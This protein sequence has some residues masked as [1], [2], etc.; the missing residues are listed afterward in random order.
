MRGWVITPLEDG[1][2]LARAGRERLDFAVATELAGAAPKRLAHQVRQ[3]LWRALQGLRGFSPVVEIAGD[4]VRAG[5]QVDGRVP[6]NAV[7]I[8]QGVLD[9]PANRARWM[10]CAK[11][12]MT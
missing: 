4:V 12:R 5:G 3:D 10:R 11:R 7:A 9:D 8:A 2:R 6:S 1:I